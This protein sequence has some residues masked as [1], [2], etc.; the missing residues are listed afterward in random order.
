M[1][2]FLTLTFLALSFSQQQPEDGRG[3]G[4]LDREWHAARRAALME[5]K[6]VQK[7][8]VVL[9]GAPTLNDYR[10]FRQDNNFWYFTGVTTPNAVLVLI[11][12][13]KEEYLFVPPVNAMQERWVG[14][15]IDPEEAKEITGIENCLTLGAKGGFG[16]GLDS[17]NLEDLLK[18][19]SRKYKTFYVQGQPAENWMMSRDQLRTAAISRTTDSFDGRPSREKQFMNKLA[20]KYKVKTVDFTNFLDAMRIVKTP[21]EAQVMREACRISG[22]A[23]Q[24]IMRTARPGMYEW[25]LGAQMTGVMLNS[26]AKGP[27]YMAIVG[28]GPNNCILHYSD[29]NRQIAKGDLVL[30][31]YGAEFNH[32]VADITRTWPVDTKFT[33][34][35]AEIYN[36]VFEAQEAAFRACKPGSTLGMVDQAAS[37][38]LADH[39]F[40]P[41]H[42]TSHWL[43]MATHDVGHPQARFKPGAVFTV[44]PGVYLPE[45]G[46]GVRIEDVVM[47]TEDGYE[48]LSKMIPRRLEEIEA[49]RAESL[50]AVSPAG[51]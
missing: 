40:R 10:Q 17:S 20:E 14:D 22:L 6:R 29:N 12:S 45:E 7:G 1:Q 5:D 24:D 34:R 25:Q 36:A 21:E 19:L 49:M 42:G 31:D 44:E 32:Y 30:I 8:V 37:A 23:H 11:P 39:G 38:V 48:I 16:G 13:K 3:Q 27:A 33:P 51:R 46:V 47:I 28:A 41:W 35:Q 26:G 43:G 18:K 15:L 4:L 50:K 2:A 9:R